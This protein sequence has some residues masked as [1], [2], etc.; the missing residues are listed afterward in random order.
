MI[1]SYPASMLGMEF[2]ISPGVRYFDE[3]YTAIVEAFSC[4]RLVV[5][6]VNFVLS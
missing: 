5:S 3:D 6:L 1:A 4:L 2:P